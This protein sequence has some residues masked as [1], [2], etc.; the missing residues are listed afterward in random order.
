MSEKQKQSHDKV[1]CD[2]LEWILSKQE[3]TSVFKEITNV[4]TTSKKQNILLAFQEHL[5]LLLFQLPVQPVQIP[6]SQ[7]ENKNKTCI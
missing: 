4:T 5:H 3:Q 1:T 6:H 2:K 7:S